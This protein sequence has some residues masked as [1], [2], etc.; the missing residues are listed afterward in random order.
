MLVFFRSKNV[1]S[2]INMSIFKFDI[3]SDQC[4]QLS[5]GLASSIGKPGK[6]L[7]SQALKAVNPALLRV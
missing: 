4:L 7:T 6:P 2:R 3:L 5:Q 1:L